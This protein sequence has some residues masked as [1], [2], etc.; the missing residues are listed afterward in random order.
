MN[1]DSNRMSRR[2]KSGWIIAVI[3]LV[4]IVNS[5]I[6]FLCM[7]DF[8]VTAWLVFNACAPSVCIFLVGFFTRSIC[9]IASS[10]PFL[11]FFGGGGLFYFGW[12]G[13]SL[14]AQVGHIAMMC[15]VSYI[16]F[17]VWK[18]RMLKD[19]AIGLLAGLILFAV[20]VPF[21]QKYVRTHPEFVARL[22]DQTFEEK[23]KGK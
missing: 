6:Y 5:T 13:T 8:P 14:I 21:Q 15:A 1:D 22:G 23:I 7:A 12:S 18:N 19:A 3:N 2:G 20:I 11:L 9:I 10:L 16:V 4:L 17:S